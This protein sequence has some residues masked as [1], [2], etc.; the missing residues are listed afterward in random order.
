MAISN[1]QKN[2]LNRAMPINN[3]VKLGDI[4]QEL[5]GKVAVN[6]ADTVA[7]DLAALKADFN[8]LLDAL[9]N[10]GLMEADAE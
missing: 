3:V 2:R 7:A 6:Q 9:K 4:V 8:D 1:S 10:A 5:Q